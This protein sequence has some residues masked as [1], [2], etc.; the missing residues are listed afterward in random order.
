[1]FIRISQAL[2]LLVLT[3]GLLRAGPSVPEPDLR[4]LTELAVPSTATA[5]RSASATCSDFNQLNS[6]IRDGRI[7]KN[8]AQQEFTSLLGRVQKEYYQRAGHNFLP[9]DWIFP[10]AGYN[11]RSIDTGK[12]H[13]FSPA[14]Y[15]YFSGNRHGGHPAF[16][17]FIHDRNQDSSDDRT[18]KPVAVLSMTGG[19]VVALEQEWSADSSLRGGKYIWV[20][21]PGNQLLV[22]YAHNQE[23]LVDLGTIVKPGDLLARVGRSGLNAAKKRSPTHLH[24]SVLQLKN[25]LPVARNVYKELQHARTV[26]AR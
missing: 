3:P 2:F 24:F 14:G 11:I 12:N 16:D 26:D 20:Y 10:L 15:N 6:M 21:D 7:N 8:S 18:G 19:V 5:T 25:S 23:L 9:A 4:E 17:L 1:M 13:G 22:Y